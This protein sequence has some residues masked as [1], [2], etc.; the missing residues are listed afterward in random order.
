M[1]V[2]STSLTN[3]FSAVE[4]HTSTTI[5]LPLATLHCITGIWFEVSNIWVLQME[6]LLFDY[7]TFK[8]IMAGINVSGYI[9]VLA[10]LCLCS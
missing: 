5:L 1:R 3:A 4:R 10:E 7:I 2:Q 6:N 9:L 8:T